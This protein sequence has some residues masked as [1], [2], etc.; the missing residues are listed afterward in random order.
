MRLI[1]QR[2]Y[3]LV[4]NICKVKRE[5]TVND[6]ERALEHR[7]EYRYREARFRRFR[8]TYKQVVSILEMLVLE[9]R[10][11]VIEP[12]RSGRA[13]KYRWKDEDGEARP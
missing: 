2:Q 12:G 8:P 5:Y 11:I 6:I 10:A 3:N 7:E 1:K 13:T 4:V 9:Q